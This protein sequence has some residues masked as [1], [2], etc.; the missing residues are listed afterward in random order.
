M[1]NDVKQDVHCPEGHALYKGNI[2]IFCL[3]FY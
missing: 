2:Q 3:Y 1:T